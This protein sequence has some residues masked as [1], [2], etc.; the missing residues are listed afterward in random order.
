MASALFLNKEIKGFVLPPVDCD[1]FRLLFSPTSFMV[2]FLVRCSSCSPPLGAVAHGRLCLFLPL[3]DPMSSLSFVPW[4]PCPAQPISV[5]HH[6]V[7]RVDLPISFPLRSP[8]PI[9]NKNFSRGLVSVP[10]FQEWL[11]LGSDITPPFAFRSSMFLFS[12]T[13]EPPFWEKVFCIGGIQSYSMF[14]QP[15]RRC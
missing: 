7:T 5:V 2:F 13:F 6:T 14:R 9:E 4:S 10:T 11:V 1:G 15:S 8:E 12:T 3:E